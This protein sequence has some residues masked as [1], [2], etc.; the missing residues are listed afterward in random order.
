MVIQAVV[1]AS[2]ATQ[3][4]Q[5]AVVV[6]IMHEQARLVD[7][8]Y[9]R[10]QHQVGMVIVVV[11]PLLAALLVVVVAAQAVLQLEHPLL[12]E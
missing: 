9:S 2:L 8:D 4:G 3:A 10:H 7:Q 1:V 12:G 11:L 5:V 6:A